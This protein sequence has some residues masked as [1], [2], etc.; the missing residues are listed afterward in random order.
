M[1]RNGTTPRTIWHRERTPKRTGAAPPTPE[2]STMTPAQRSKY[3][4]AVHE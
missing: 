3:A 2:S 1:P 4:L